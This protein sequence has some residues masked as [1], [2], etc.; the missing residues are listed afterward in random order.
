MK[1]YN[2]TDI[3]GKFQSFPPA[4]GPGGNIFTH[5][6]QLPINAILSRLQVQPLIEKGSQHHELHAPVIIFQQN[7]LRYCSNSICM[8][9]GTG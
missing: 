2:K 8:M 9:S 1:K 4:G 7:G 3:N 5:N 6:Q